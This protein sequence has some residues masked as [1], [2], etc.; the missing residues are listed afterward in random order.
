MFKMFKKLVQTHIRRHWTLHNAV[1]YHL[2][3]GTHRS[4]IGPGGPI[5]DRWVTEPVDRV[6]IIANLNFKQLASLILKLPY[7]HT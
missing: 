6:Q 2:G 4:V 3:E 1:V 5:A 7:K